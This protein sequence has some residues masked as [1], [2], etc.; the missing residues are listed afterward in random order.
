MKRFFGK[1]YIFAALFL[2]VWLVFSIANFV[3]GA[4]QWYNLFEGFTKVQNIDDL[5]EWIAEVEADTGEDLLGNENFID[6][7]G[8]VQK[9]L[10]KREF[11]NF[12][13][14]RDD[15]GMLYYGATWPLGTDGLEEYVDRVVRMQEYVESQ[16][17]KLLVVLPPSKILA[18]V[19]DVPRTWPLND[20]NARMD[21][22]LTLL[23]QNGVKAIDL[24]TKLQQSGSTLEE[25]FF[26]TDHHWTPLA[27]FY[28][29][30]EIV[31]QI[32]ETFGD[33]WDPTGYYT[34]LNNYNSYTYENCMLGSSGRNTGAVYSGIE[35]YTLLWPKF[36]T[37]F[38]WIS[39]NEGETTVR[40]GDFTESLLDKSQLEIDNWYHTSANRVYLH[41]ITD[42]DKIINNNNPDGPKLK[43]L[44]DS[45][46]SPTACFLAPMCSEIDMM[47]TRAS[48]DQYDA[49]AFVRDGDYD[50]L[51]LEIYPYNYDDRSF[52]FFQES[53]Q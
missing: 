41:E 8:Y 9:L 23:Y 24:R 31:D 20:P 21:K 27:G 22:I 36:S 47:W 7:Y 48:A 5:E 12:A 38:T 16:G 45:Y 49:E 29:A 42:Q 28:A 51:I 14:V 11:N 30:Q 35:D 6:T 37:D 40:E 1:K 17:A 52:N 4:E 46:F 26:K 15:D 10:G 13:F 43:V 2:I 53:E 18:G 50:Y 34:N 3:V 25:L 32:R 39:D 19:S 44:R 33:D